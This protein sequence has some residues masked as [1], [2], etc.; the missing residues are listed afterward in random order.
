[1]YYLQGQLTAN[2]ENQDKVQFHTF[3]LYISIHAF[4]CTYTTADRNEYDSSTINKYIPTLTN[5]LRV[6][7]IQ[8]HISVTS[9]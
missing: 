5:Y 3:F 6:I 9:F 7:Y 2:R 4:R 8:P 1:M